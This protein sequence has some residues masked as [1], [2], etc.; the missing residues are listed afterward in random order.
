MPT[1]AA[2]PTPMPFRQPTQVS[3]ITSG[4]SLPG[5]SSPSVMPRSVTASAWQPVL[6]DWPA[7]TGRNSARITSRSIVSW[8]MP[9][10]AAARNAVS[11]LSCSHGMAQLQAVHPGRGEALLLLDADHAAGL[12]GDLDRL[13]LEHGLAAHQADQALL[14]VEHRIDRIVPVEHQA[15][16]VLDR[17]RG[18]QREGAAQHDLLELARCGR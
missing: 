3:F 10:T 17:H 11:R 2:M 12:Q 6:P 5:L 7:S 13:R 4:R 9:T 15:H 14:G 8:N 1:A 18:V 16:R